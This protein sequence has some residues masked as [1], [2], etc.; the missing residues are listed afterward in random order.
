MEKGLYGYLA[1]QLSQSYEHWLSP[2]RPWRSRPVEDACVHVLRNLKRTGPAGS[3]DPWFWVPGAR[4]QRGHDLN[5][6]PCTY[7][8]MCGFAIRAKV[9][10]VGVAGVPNAAASSSAVEPAWA[11]A[12]AAALVLCTSAP[13]LAVPERVPADVPAGNLVLDPLDLGF[14]EHRL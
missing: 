14:R 3:A 4:L 5:V 11:T 12:G 13:G 2:A 6:A 10:S 9:T 8:R 1:A 7:M